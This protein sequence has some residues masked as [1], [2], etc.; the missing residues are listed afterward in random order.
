MTD[1]RLHGLD[2]L[3]ALM[4]L[5]GIVLHGAQM[6]MTMQ[7]GFDYYTDTAESVVMDGIL[8]FINTFRMPVFFFL[9]GFFTAMLYQKY[10]LG[11]MLR[12]RVDRILIPFLLFLPPLAIILNL[13]WIA[14]SNLQ[15]TGSIGF[16]LEHLTYRSS[17]LWDNT[18][19]LWFL[20]YLLF[21]VGVMTPVLY[22]WQKLGEGRRAALSQRLQRFPL[23]G[24]PGLVLI[25]LLFGTLA[26]G[27]Y[28]GRLNGN[29][30]WVPYLPSLTYFFGCFL[31][32][33]WIWFQRSYLEE[34][35]QRCWR[36]L[37]VAMLA[38]AIGVPA[39]FLQGPYG[40]ANYALLHP[41]VAV[42]NGISVVFFIVGFTGLFCRYFNNYNPVTRY[43]SDAAY[44]VFLAHQ[45]FLTLFGIGLHDWQVGAVPKF[46]VVTLATAACCL[47]SYE[48]LVR[49]RW[50]GRVLGE[51]PVLKA[52]DKLGVVPT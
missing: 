44:W 22:L 14:A 47:L 15:A 29:I 9:S 39:F 7:L 25:G 35:S 50:I 38:L 34:F 23:A 26:L 51:R 43:L 5:L 24:V 48:Y 31:F 40:E 41:V 1:Q 2:F 28:T 19:H 27:N 32:G 30:L 21:M 4:M 6:Y 11:G 18:H 52:D 13:M 10:H 45:P 16:A 33:W 36:Y 3:R 12:N 49:G 20:Y 46:L 42:F 8:I 17:L 37:L